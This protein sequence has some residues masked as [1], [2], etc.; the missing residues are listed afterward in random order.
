MDPRA[1]VAEM[2]AELQKLPRIYTPELRT[3]RKS[4]SE[5]LAAEEPANVLMV[6][7]AL[8][9]DFE[10]DLKWIAY[11]LIRCHVGA[12]WAIEQDQIEDF[13][14]RVLTWY[15]TDA[16]GTGLTGPLWAKGRLPR[17]LFDAWSRSESVWLRRAA[18]VSTVGRNMKKPDVEATLTLCHRLAG[19]REDMVEKAI[20]WT[21]RFLS[22][23]D[24][25]AVA[26]FMAKHG[27]DFGS[28]VKREVRHKLATGV[29]RARR[30]AP[31]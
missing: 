21:L 11:E 29:K 12:F 25:A 15:A 28:L 17:E 8:E 13:A 20:S 23:R 16:F 1:I 18:L 4:W 14:G 24:R 5:R 3:F 26:D 7:Q 9:G 19:D 31:S 6:A 30:T 10:Q 27:E 2:N 22:Q